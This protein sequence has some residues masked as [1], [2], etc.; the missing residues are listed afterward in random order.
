MSLFTLFGIRFG[1]SSIIGLIPWLG[2]AIDLYFAYALVQMCQQVSSD[3]FSSHDPKNTST[4]MHPPSRQHHHNTSTPTATGLPASLTSK[5]YT[6][7][8]IDF[9]LG[10]VPFL[11]D[12]A[13]ASFKCNTKNVA[14][15]EKYLVEKYA[16]RS[17]SAGDKARSGLEVFPEDAG[18]VPGL[19]SV[20][21]SQG[22][23][24][25]YAQYGSV[26][27]SG[28]QGQG[29]GQRR[30]EEGEVGR[31]QNGGSR[32]WFG[33]GGKQGKKSDVERG[34]GGQE[35]GTIPVTR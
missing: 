21:Q 6:N 25:G 18:M 20:G 8:A 3:P 11:G 13:D 15:L 31:N 23:G 9:A 12:I 26:N 22:Q 30:Q 16:P 32:K 2:D 28:V 5:M 7:V 14:L 19:E 35:N 1:W 34:Q 29:Q 4:T 17:M 27:V 24:Q 10:L 33:F